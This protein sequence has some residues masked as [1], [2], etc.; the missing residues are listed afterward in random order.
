MPDHSYPPAGTRVRWTSQANAYRKTKEGV[1]TEIS[2]D[3]AFLHPSRCAFREE[4]WPTTGYKVEHAF[5]TAYQLAPSA[6]VV[7]VDTVNG[8]PRRSGPRYYRP[9][10]EWLEM[11][12]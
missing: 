2:R 10:A 8:Q 12:D 4:D 11:V 6:L 1:V 3:G 7:E 5:F 9:R